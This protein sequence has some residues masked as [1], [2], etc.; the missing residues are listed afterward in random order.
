M[1]LFKKML[2]LLGLGSLL[3]GCD[4]PMLFWEQE[5]RKIVDDVVEIEEK[6]HPMPLSPNNEST[7]SPP[8]VKKKVLNRKRTI[9]THQEFTK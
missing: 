1:K 9:R 2:V 8:L 7:V 3:S 5:G 6:L 4:I